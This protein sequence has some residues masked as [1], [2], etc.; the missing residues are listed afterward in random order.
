VRN[1]HRPKENFPG[2]SRKFETSLLGRVESYRVIRSVNDS[3]RRTSTIIIS[4]GTRVDIFTR[5]RRV[6][7][8]PIGSRT[9][10]SAPRRGEKI[11]YPR[12]FPLDTRV[13][14]PYMSAYTRA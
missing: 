9:A 3:F 1:R 14:V 8:R 2:D 10:K 11:I 7:N 6:Y 13:P 12:A 5:L 4:H